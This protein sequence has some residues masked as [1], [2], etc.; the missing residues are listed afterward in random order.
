MYLHLFVDGAGYDVAWSQRQTFVVLLH[1]R[2]AVRQ[3]QYA[4]IAAH[5][6]GDEIGGVSLVG[7]MKHRGVEL[8]K[9]HIGHGSLGAI[10]H[11]DTIAGSNHG[12]RGGQV[13]GTASTGTHHG[14]LTEI[15]IYLLGI[16]IK[17][18][19]TIAVDIGRTACNLST[20]VVLGDNFY[21][22]VVFFYVD[23]R[24]AANSLHQSALNLG[25]SII[26]VMQ[27]AEL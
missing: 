23:V 18:V 19:S 27:D 21:G 24:I 25:T 17:H 15:C 11:G 16:G 22:K 20:K 3:F 6:L 13:N 8:Y 4:A 5:S 9:L 2:L 1:K 14:Y 10:N 7:I 26:F 12:V